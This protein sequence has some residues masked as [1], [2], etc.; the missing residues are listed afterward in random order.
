[1]SSSTQKAQTTAFE[2]ALAEFQ[3]ELRPKDKHKFR[4]TTYGH[5][6]AEI[7]DIQTKLM[8]QRRGK[9]LMRLKSFLEAIDH[10]G[11]VVEVFGNAS[12]LVA[13]VWVRTIPHHTHNIGPFSN[14]TASLGAYE[15]S[16]SGE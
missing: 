9:H 16:S 12:L 2:T 8:R 7:E 3:S 5:V 6:K 1:M 14:L 10:F 11:K 13:F 15:I 4:N